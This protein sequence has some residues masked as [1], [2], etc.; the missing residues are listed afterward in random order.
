MSNTEKASP[1]SSAKLEEAQE[2]RSYRTEYSESQ[3]KID[4]EG[5]ND[6]SDEHREYLLQRHGTLDLD[7]IPDMSDADPY[8]WSQKKKVTNLFLV[9]F[10][11][12]MATFTAAA[13]MAAFV[14]IAK[15]LDIEVQSASYLTSLVIAILGGAP[16]FWRPLSQRYGRRPIFMISL[17]CSL[18]GNIGCANAHS[19]ATM[20]L[21]RAIVGFFICPAAAIG[22]GV[23]VETFFK[24]ERARYMGIWTIFVTLGVPVAPFI[25][26]FVALRVGYRWIYYILAITNAVQLILYF[27]FGPESRYIRGS[28]APEDE[29]NKSDFKKQYM[30]FR[31]IDKTP[32]TWYD[33]VEPLAYAA[34][35]CVMLP[36]VAYAMEFL[37]TSIMT[38]VEIPQL[39]PELFG[40]NTQQNGLQMISVIVGTIV[41][42]QIGGRMSDLWMSA[43]RRKL[44]G[45][46]PE[47]EYRL[48]LS[49]F[50]F[51]LCV[52][53]VVV[54]LV[55]LY[56]AG[57]TWNVTPLIGVGIAAAGNQVVTTVL[58]TYS[59]DCYR[60]DAASVGVF[61]TFV[62][63]IWG[64]IGPF[65]FPQSIEEVGYRETAGIAVAMMVA[66]CVIPILLIQWRGR[67]WR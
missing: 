47:P 25:F 53:G 63:Q 33:F 62:R 39:F 16:L 45:R 40:F 65:W 3:L 54:F 51:V 30:S 43:R 2:P 1:P 44:N 48:W 60:H 12:M 24:D 50:G 34:R 11:A 52:I 49:Y 29:K 10:H 5:I 28:Q 58:V 46:S 22:S 55:Q 66:F 19:Y 57:H 67:T 13:I 4:Q 9:A 32:M 21:C 37:W 31:R 56:N 27:F 38:T 14:N 61:I 64:F 59:V 15:D 7:P 26:G 23:V 20:C 36:A 42:E 41:G 6:L 18:V 8:N 17:I 35:P